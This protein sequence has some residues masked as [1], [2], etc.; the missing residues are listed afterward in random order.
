FYM[1]SGNGSWGDFHDP[2][3]TGDENMQLAGLIDIDQSTNN[4]Y[5]RSPV[6]G[7]ANNLP[8]G[9]QSAYGRLANVPSN[10]NRLLYP[11]QS[12]NVLIVND[13][14]LGQS[15]VPIYNF[16]FA[17]P[18]GGTPLAENATGYLM[19]NARWMIQATGADG[20]RPDAT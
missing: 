20:F 4:R 13:P 18:N 1:S 11:D 6:P 17:N 16:N 5:I 2:A 15:N 10:S 19:R 7:Y 8:A 14:A 9:T 12:T 3:A